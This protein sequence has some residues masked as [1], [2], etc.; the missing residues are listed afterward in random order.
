MTTNT[1]NAIAAAP[2]SRPRTNPLRAGVVAVFCGEVISCSLV[3][4]GWWVVEPV[5]GS[6]RMVIGF[7]FRMERSVRRSGG[8][9]GRAL[10]SLTREALTLWVAAHGAQVCV[11]A[12]AGVLGACLQQGADLA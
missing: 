3:S 1:A 8:R 11:G 10:T 6:R 12:A 9:S 5:W 7:F 4:V 2:T